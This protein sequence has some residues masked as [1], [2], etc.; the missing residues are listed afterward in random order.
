L[1]KLLD[2]VPHVDA[3]FA[4]NGIAIDFENFIA[5]FKFRLLLGCAT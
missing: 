2:H 4:S 3:R 5:D 1:R